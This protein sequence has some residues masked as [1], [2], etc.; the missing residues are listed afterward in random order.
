MNERLDLEAD[1]DG[2]LSAEEAAK[3]ER[4]LQNSSELQRQLQE[5]E[6]LRGQMRSLAPEISRNSPLQASGQAPFIANPW[7][8]LMAVVL[9]L[10]LFFLGWRQGVFPRQPGFEPWDVSPMMADHLEPMPSQGTLETDDVGHLTRWLQPQLGFQP[11]VPNWSWARLCSGRLCWIRRRKLARIR[12]RDGET[13][14]SLFVFPESRPGTRKIYRRNQYQAV[15][16]SQNDLGFVVVMP[17]TLAHR[18]EDF[19]S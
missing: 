12:Y 4:L 18:L 10:V 2:D 17:S 11:R 3:F 9:S 8:V 6:F 14:F 7:R 1:F 19:R 5:L 15:Y 16:W 13:E